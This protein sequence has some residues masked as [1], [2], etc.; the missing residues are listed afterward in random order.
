MPAT[1]LTCTALE[2]ACHAGVSWENISDYD[3]FTQAVRA[4]LMARVIDLENAELVYG[5]PA[6][7]GLNGMITTAGILTLTATGVPRALPAARQQRR[8]LGGLRPG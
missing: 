8:L 1:K 3:A 7:G 5:N 2:L 6:T 4:E